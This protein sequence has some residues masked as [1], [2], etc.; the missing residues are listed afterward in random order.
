MPS[1]RPLGKDTE[2]IIALSERG[3]KTREI[4]Y[5]LSLSSAKVQTTLNYHRNKEYRKKMYFKKSV[6]I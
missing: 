6:V 2:C 3:L 4:A 1:G 5:T